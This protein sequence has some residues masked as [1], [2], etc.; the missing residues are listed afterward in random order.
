MSFAC[1]VP[2]EREVDSWI[3]NNWVLG[4]VYACSADRRSIA[5]AR[6]D[7]PGGLQNIN[8]DSL[9][10]FLQLLTPGKCST[11]KNWYTFLNIHPPFS[12]NFQCEQLKE[13]M[14]HVNDEMDQTQISD[15]LVSTTIIWA[16]YLTSPLLCTY[17]DIKEQLGV[18]IA[19]NAIRIFECGEEIWPLL[20]KLHEIDVEIVKARYAIGQR[21]SFF[22]TSPPRYL[23][24][25]V[26]L[27]NHACHRHSNVI[28]KPVE[29]QPQW[30]RTSRQSISQNCF[31]A[32]AETRIS[33]GERV[34]ATYDMDDIELKRTRGIECSLCLPK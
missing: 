7:C 5:D 25:P 24:G 4:Q 2:V 29:H 17:F 34:Y 22:G 16:R 8:N 15:L 1:Q 18:R 13:L 20:G 23:S 6:G 9:H 12:V 19:D 3:I 26:S 32:V 33:P 10:D 30:N 11:F 31:V 21:W 14:E 28:I 27:I